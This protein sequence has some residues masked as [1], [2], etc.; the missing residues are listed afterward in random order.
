VSVSWKV[1]FLI[2][3]SKCRAYQ[4]INQSINQSIRIYT[5]VDVWNTCYCY[6]AHS[7]V[8]LLLEVSALLPDSRSSISGCLLVGPLSSS[9][10]A[11]SLQSPRL[12]PLPHSHS[13]GR[14][15]PTAAHLEG[16]PTQSTSPSGRTPRQYQPRQARWRRG[17]PAIPSSS[18][19]LNIYNR[20]C[21]ERTLLL[22]C[23]QCRFP[24]AGS[25]RAPPRL[26]FIYL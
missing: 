16:R 24:P 18:A 25:F 12:L 22:P 15:S 13:S 6:P 21:T 5:I 1:I 9:A 20:R 23:S 2:E 14:C 10:T 17:K 7:V 11:K 8:F 19:E 26:S 4:S 3:I